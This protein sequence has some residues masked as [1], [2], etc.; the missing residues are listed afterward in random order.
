LIKTYGRAK[1]TALL[2]DLRDGQTTEAAL[3]SVYGLDLDGLEAA[4]RISIGAKR[5]ADSSKPT[6]LPTP[7]QVPTFVPVGGV[8]VATPESFTPNPTALHAS[9]TPTAASQTAVP[10]ASASAPTDQPGAT[11]LLKY[12]LVC[13][14]SAVRLGALVIIIIIIV[15]SRHARSK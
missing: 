10:T 12:G 8:P 11:T 6:P 13:L 2:L 15:R 4:W 9:A 3:Q 7:T 14:V 1:M 5:P